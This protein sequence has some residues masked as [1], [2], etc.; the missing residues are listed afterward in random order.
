VEFQV[1]L[2]TVSPIVAEVILE[3]DGQKRLYRNEKEFWNR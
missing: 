2:R 3:I 1:N